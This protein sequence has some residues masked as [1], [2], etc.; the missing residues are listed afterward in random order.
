MRCREVAKV[1]LNGFCPNPCPRHK[2]VKIAANVAVLHVDLEEKR[3]AP[4]IK[5]GVGKNQRMLPI[6]K[7]RS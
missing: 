7:Y 4:L 2:A 5:R 1:C 6:Y 3:S